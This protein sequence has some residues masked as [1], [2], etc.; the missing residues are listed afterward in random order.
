MLG[1]REDFCSCVAGAVDRVGDTD[2]ARIIPNIFRAITGQ[3]DHVTLNGDGSAVRDFVHVADVASGIRLA[4]S[5]CTPGS[6]QT[7][8]LGSGIGTSM[9][10]VVATAE[11]VT[12]HPV[13][14]RRMP[15]KPEPPRLVADITR[16]R[17]DLGWQLARSELAQ[18]ACVGKD[19]TP[20]KS[21]AKATEV[22]I[23]YRSSGAE[24]AL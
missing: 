23:L 24:T 17:G 18:A 4:L 15:P 2:P 20:C 13:T 9:A 21:V 8:N 22:R 12:W 14:V 16:A 5:A 10:E 3:L 19:R 6:S 11:R 7:V 1:R